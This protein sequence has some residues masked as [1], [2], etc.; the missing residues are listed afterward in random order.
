MQQVIDKP[1]TPGLNRLINVALWQLSGILIGGLLPWS[2]IGFAH[3]PQNPRE[4]DRWVFEAGLAALVLGVLG[5]TV[6]TVIGI[7]DKHPPLTWSR[8]KSD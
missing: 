2:G 7:C 6:G 1:P 3:Y 5:A 4:M 8:R